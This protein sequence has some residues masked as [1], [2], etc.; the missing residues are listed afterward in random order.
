MLIKALTP[1]FFAAE[2]TRTPVL[3]AAISV[4]V[5]IV[6]SLILFPV[7]GHVGIALAT[8]T[9]AWVNVGLLIYGLKKRG[10]FAAD[11][12]LKSRGVR[13]ILASAVMGAALAG[14]GEVCALWFAHSNLTAILALIGLIVFGST[15][16]GV[17]VLALKASSVAELKSAFR[18]RA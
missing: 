13:L 11:A 8:A 6:G 5:N 17:M 16:Y 1:A 18:R 2:N 3:Y 10:S 14:Y 4:G 9:A 7:F 12:R 15:V